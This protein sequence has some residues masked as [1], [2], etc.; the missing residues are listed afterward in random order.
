MISLPWTDRAGRLSPLK[1]TVFAALFVPAILLAV[2]AATNNLGSKP[3][4]EAIH[5]AGD[6]AIRIL[7]ISLAV[8]PLRRIADWPRL[9]LVRRMIGLGALAYAVLHL[10]LYAFEQDW[11]WWTIGR[12]I[13]V[14]IYL[15]IGF[16]A[17]LG[18]VALG[19]TSTD[20]A[21]RRLGRTWN[22]LHKLAYPIA[23]LGILHFYMQSKI[24]VS[25]ATLMAGLFVLLMG[26]RLAQARGLPLASPLVL[27]A[28]AVAAALSTA[29][30][31]VLWYAAATGVPWQ[32]ILAA[33]LQ[34]AFRI[35]AAWW[36]LGTGLAVA[37]LPLLR[38][39]LPGAPAPR[40]G[41]G[42]ESAAKA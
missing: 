37:A 6:W 38:R 15:L 7:L 33:N 41:R 19:A 4:T 17:I 42:A 2:N 24:D 30:I 36:V 18:L 35:S 23:A 28:V 12:E 14:R 13:V 10:G 27:A 31:E 29:L 16:V 34:F 32:R 11:K 39:L 1:L 21:I 9:I 40:R 22:R 26:Y 20:A 8:T 3:T 5:E 25:E